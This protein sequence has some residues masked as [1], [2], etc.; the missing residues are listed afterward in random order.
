MIMRALGGEL[1]ITYEAVRQQI[2]DLRRAGWVT[3]E[4][5]SSATGAEDR[6]RGPASRQYRLSAAAEHLFPKNYDALSQELVRHV[7]ERFGGAGV[8][9]I[10]ER[11][12]DERVRRWQPLLKSMNLRQRLKALC[13]LYED[14]DA[15]MEVQWREGAPAL[16]ERNCPFL[17][18]ARAHPAICSVSVNTLDGYRLPRD[19]RA[20]LPGRT[21]AVCPRGSISPAPRAR[22]LPSSRERRGLGSR[23]VAPSVRVDLLI[24]GRRARCARNHLA[25][26][27][28]RGGGCRLDVPGRRI[29]DCAV[30]VREGTVA[31]QRPAGVPNCAGSPLC[32]D[33]MNAS[34]I[35]SRH[36]IM[37]F[38]AIG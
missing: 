27:P 11:M 2:A 9:E 12:T 18:V 10:L 17:N 35:K 8:R 28:T 15:Y 22:A 20:A 3:P 29:G 32:L 31:V 16:I 25:P 6:K 21:G 36:S 24:L 23:R 34:I 19:P 33:R 5:A 14:N 1:G 7:I 13:S 37:V 30:A 26:D 4:R 38:G